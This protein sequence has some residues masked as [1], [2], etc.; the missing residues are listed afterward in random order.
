MLKKMAQ[1]AV[2]GF[3]ATIL[4]QTI[5]FFFMAQS[6]RSPVTA[7]FSAHFANETAAVIAQLALCS[8]IGV[9]FACGSAIF[10][11][12]RW[13]YLLQG[14]VHFAMT[15]AVWMP[16]AWICWRP[17]SIG[18]ALIAALGWLFTYAVNWFVQYLLYRRSIRQ[19]NVKIVSFGSE[20][21][22]DE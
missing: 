15:A 19:L 6:G 1:R 10:E 18:T 8:L 13:S 7:E 4:I 22:T 9:A 3:S 12:E 2:V 21:E 11:I 14:A 17:D 20:V 5:I 16:V